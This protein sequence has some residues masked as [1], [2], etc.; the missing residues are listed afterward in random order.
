MLKRMLVEPEK[1]TK[2]LQAASADL[3]LPRYRALEKADIREKSPGDLVTIA[4]VEVEHFLSRELSTLLPGSTVVG[5]EAYS[6]NPAVLDRLT[7]DGTVWLVD[8]VDG[9]VNFAHG[10]ET[11][12]VM[13]ALIKDGEAVFSWIHDPLSG[14]T[15]V[16]EKG[17]GAFWGDERLSVPVAPGQADMH[18]QINFGYFDPETRPALKAAADS[19]FGS[20]RRL[21]CAGH[22][23]LAQARGTRH[24]AFYRHLWSW[25]HVPGTL[26]LREAGGSVALIDGGPIRPGDRV[27]GLI[28]AGS[29]M[30]WNDI[31]AFLDNWR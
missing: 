8:P 22:D 20:L 1:V 19:H 9:T 16:A 27:R 18:G 15:A 30:V 17:S 21:G 3:I 5:E 14:L 23:F 13:A 29:D 28:S 2:L 12:C 6:K 4:D 25:D 26:L 10:R 7:G 31:K 24:F 11:F